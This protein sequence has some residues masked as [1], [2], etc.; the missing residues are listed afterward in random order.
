MAG[1]RAWFLA[2]LAGLGLAGA[3]LLGRGPLARLLAQRWERQLASVSE[4]ERSLLLKQLISLGDG[5]IP[6]L[7]AAAGSPR[8]DIAQAGKQTLLGEIERWK[9]LEASEHEPKV[10]ILA[11]ALADQVD[12]W[13]PTARIDAAELAAR[14]LREFPAVAHGPIAVACEKVLR[15]AAERQLLAERELL[16]GRAS[17]A[18]SQ[19]ASEAPVEPPWSRPVEL[20]RP[21]ELSP[22]IAGG[23][24]PIELSGEAAPGTT[25]TTQPSGTSDAA[26]P[27]GAEGSRPAGAGA[28]GDPPP[29]AQGLDS[30][31][32]S[33]PDAAWPPGSLPRGMA[34][35]NGPAA[36]S[37]TLEHV[38]TVELM[39]RLQNDGGREAEKE[40][41]W[42]GFTD[43]E[44]E[45]ARQLF[46][47]DPQIR[48]HLAELL[49]SLQSIDA[50]PWLLALC[51]DEDAEVRLIA[52][53]LIATSGDPALKA[54][55]ERIARR[56]ADP[57]LK[58]QAQ[59]MTKPGKT[60]LR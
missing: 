51:R 17:P 6:S 23:S 34:G 37:E 26:L 12:G 41:R 4:E 24:L 15:T 3:V 31:Q 9:S 22:R 2:V 49:P 7:V 28:I 25:A 30:P 60:T 55:A 27:A 39:R 11:Q 13:G 45:L 53:S 8:E 52:V 1:M 21:A 50:A 57:R 44:L 38:E 40:L 20:A 10:R 58:N 19:P 43:V 35:T 46:D 56:D 16:D 48:K 59:R 42:R 29:L 36:L 54:E 47:P 14:I 18:Q 33:A 5:G 32:N